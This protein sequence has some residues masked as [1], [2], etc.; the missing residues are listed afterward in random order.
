[1]IIYALL[2]LGVY[3]VLKAERRDLTCPKELKELR[4]ANG[5]SVFYDSNVCTEGK[6]KFYADGQGS[7]NDSVN[8]LLERIKFTNEWSGVIPKWRRCVVIAV[9]GGILIGLLQKEALPSG[10]E[11]L[12]STIVISILS[13][14]LYSYYEYHYD[15][16]PKEFIKTDIELIR[17]KL[18]LKTKNLFPAVD[19]V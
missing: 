10:R 2:L 15:K 3:K 14:G 6:S 4:D 9:I 7:P 16:Y 17:S 18:R 8:T 12:V 13:Y 5:K 19:Y 1:M 11:L